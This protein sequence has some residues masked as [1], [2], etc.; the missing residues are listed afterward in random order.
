MLAVDTIINARWI[1]HC[2]SNQPD[3]DST[4]NAAP[5]ASGYFTDHSLVIA[6]ERIVD[7]LPHSLAPQR[8]QATN[9]IDLKQHMLIPGLIN[10]HTHSPMNLLRGLADDLQLKQWLNEHI[11]PAENHWV[12]EEFVRDGSGLAI[13]EML[14]GGVTQFNDMYFYPNVTGI[15]ASQAGIKAHVGAAIFDFPCAWGSGPDEYF[16]HGEALCAQFA[17]NPL[18]TCNIG[19]HAPYTVSDENFLRVAKF[20]E[21][22]DCRINLHLH[23][24]EHEVQVSLQ[25][26]GKR[27]LQRLSSLGL[28]EQPVIA[29]HMTALNQEDLD[30]ACHHQLD[31]VTCPES[32]MKLASGFCPVYQLQQLGLNV[33]IG[34][35]GAASNNDLDMFS[36]IRTTA[37]LAKAVSKEPT[38]CSAKTTLEMATI[39]GAKALG[40]EQLSGSLTPGK[41]ADVVAV[42]MDNIETLPLYNPISQLVYASGRQ[43]VSDVWVR[44]KRLLAERKLTTMD[45]EDLLE[46]ARLWAEKIGQ[47]DGQGAK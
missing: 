39:N 46:R 6:A 44:G 10:N 15:V 41:D 43:Q 34:T 24:T 11:W 8:Y 5:P 3:G 18:V 22:H 30:L 26:Y 14:R 21:K 40:V 16:K 17:G 2:L 7:I 31:I 35:D 47:S 25:K 29:V 45:E 12:S 4:P 33:S 27:P 37:L 1:A 42:K 38:A 13:A 20:A 9:I 19:P 36:E 28:F 32:N 23:E